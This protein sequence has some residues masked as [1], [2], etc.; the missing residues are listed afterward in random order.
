MDGSLRLSIWPDELFLF[1]PI[2]IPPNLSLFIPPNGLFQY[3]QRLNELMPSTVTSARQ[4]F[5]FHDPDES[6][7]RKAKKQSKW[8]PTNGPNSRGHSNPQKFP[9]R[10][11]VAPMTSG[12]PTW[13]AKRN[14]I[15]PAS[16]WTPWSMRLFSATASCV[17]MFA[18]VGF[19]WVLNISPELLG[20]LNPLVLWLL[21]LCFFKPP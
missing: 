17:V 1:I 6:L 12:N 10:L 2:Y 19:S 3:Y 9:L 5:R 15:N 20:V 8:K 4:I 11:G 7:G 13:R 18:I 14:G 16:R 21:Y